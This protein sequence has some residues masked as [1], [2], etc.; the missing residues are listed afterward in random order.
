MCAL[1]WLARISERINVTAQDLPEPVEPTTAKCLASSLSTTT[2]AGCASLLLNEPI[3]MLGREGRVYTVIKSAS[4]A[5]A[6][7][8]P[9]A[10][11]CETPR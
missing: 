1:G 2:N 6:T 10:G 8:A 4:L 3:R 7:A 9:N 5:T 11:G